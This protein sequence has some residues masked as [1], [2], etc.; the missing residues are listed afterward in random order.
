VVVVVD[1]VW[2]LL[3]SH[4]YVHALTAAADVCLVVQVA[5]CCLY[6]ICRQETKPFMLIDL[7]DLLQ[8]G[9]GVGRVFFF[10]GGCY[11]AGICKGGGGASDNCT[12][13]V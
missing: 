4:W 2:T 3:C 12:Y 8:V 6:I 9:D 11:M 7:S 1:Y 10:G 13:S 5:A